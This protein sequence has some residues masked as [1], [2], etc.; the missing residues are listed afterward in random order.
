MQT[1]PFPCKK[2]KLLQR[3]AKIQNGKSL[4]YKNFLVLYSKTYF[5]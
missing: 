3:Y 2:Q 4:E 1:Y 5:D